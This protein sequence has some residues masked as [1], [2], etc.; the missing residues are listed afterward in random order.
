MFLGYPLYLDVSYIYNDIGLY[1]VRYCD[2][3]I[4]NLSDKNWKT[5]VNG[6]PFNIIFLGYFL[7]CEGALLFYL[8]ER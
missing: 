6:K 3:V 4:Y 8:E 5:S 1:I 7:T 2:K